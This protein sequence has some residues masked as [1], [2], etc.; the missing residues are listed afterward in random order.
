MR[1]NDQRSLSLELFMAQLA[2]ITPARATPI[3]PESDLIEV[4]ARDDHAFSRLADLLNSHY[5]VGGLSTASVRS[6]ERV[7]VE[8]FFRRC[9]VEVLGLE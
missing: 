2:E 8:S 6:E 9:V 3:T 5:G 1:E 7:T 4:L